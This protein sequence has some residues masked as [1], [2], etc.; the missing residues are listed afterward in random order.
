[1]LSSDFYAIGYNRDADYYITFENMQDVPTDILDL[2]HSNVILQSRNNND[3]SCALNLIQEGNL[4][5]IK[6]YCGYNIQR[7]PLKPT[8]YRLSENA[9]LLSNI[10][11][12]KISCENFSKTMT[13]NKIQAVFFLRCGCKLMAGNMVF[14]CPVFKCS[15]SENITTLFTPS[16][17]VNLAFLTEFFEANSLIDIAPDHLLNEEI[18]VD[19]PKLTIATKEYDAK[20]ARGQELMYDMSI[21]INQTK[22][23]SKMYDDLS[24]YLYNKMIMASL[25]G[26]DSN[27]FDV[28]NVFHWVVLI[29]GIAAAAALVWLYILHNKYRSLVILLAAKRTAAQMS[30]LRYQNYY[31]TAGHQHRSQMT[32]P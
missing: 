14:Y 17:T 5:N 1:M 21:L 20:V 3:T 16:Y 27:H 11:I 22:L 26:L 30:K 8:G 18:E 12:V 9:I 13:I 32:C 23:D 29:V 6:K 31:S 7:K 19:L 25:D 15:I 4:E 24:H 28:F 2:K 10:S